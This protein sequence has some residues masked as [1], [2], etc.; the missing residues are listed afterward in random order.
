MRYI[1]NKIY[2]GKEVKIRLLFMLMLNNK[3]LFAFLNQILERIPYLYK[4]I[5]KKKASIDKELEPVDFF[6]DGQ[7][8][9]TASNT[10][11]IEEFKIFWEE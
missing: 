11:Y 8:T 7:F 5:E 1:M 10:N 9:I 4:N 6:K 2:E 3:K